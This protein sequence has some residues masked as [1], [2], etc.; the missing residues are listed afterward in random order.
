MLAAQLIAAFVVDW[1]VRGEPPTA[2][3]IAGGLLIIGAVALVR[4]PAVP[5]A[6][7]PAGEL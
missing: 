7:L 2:G 3:V 6:A 4:R 5:A 1:V